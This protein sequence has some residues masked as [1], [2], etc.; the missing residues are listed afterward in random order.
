[1]T[2]DDRLDRMKSFA[3]DQIHKMQVNSL[4]RFDV[5]FD[6]WMSEKKLR[7]EGILEEAL[8]YFS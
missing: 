5:Q 2:E 6:N 8:S 1:M 7:T 3:L 4:N